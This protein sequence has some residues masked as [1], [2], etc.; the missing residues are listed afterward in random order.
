MVLPGHT[1]V[2]GQ[3]RTRSGT[4][5]QLAREYPRWGYRRI[6]GEVLGLGYRI[7]EE[8]IRRILAAA[9]LGSFIEKSR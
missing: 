5:E 4:G 1:G 9:G 6:Q 2:G 7:G 3:S 8:T